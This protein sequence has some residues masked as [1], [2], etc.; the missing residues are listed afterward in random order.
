LERAG[1]DIFDGVDYIIPVPLHRSRL[2]KRRY[3]QAGLIAQ[4]LSKSIDK[5]CLVDGLKRTRAT[6]AQ[7]YLH[8]KERQKNV[9]NAFA[10]QNKYQSKLKG[11]TILLI[12][13]VYTTGATINECSKELLSHQVQNVR[14]LTL[15]RVIKLSHI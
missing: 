8:R 11:K 4:Y 13:D 15:S 14:V 12:D 5:P 6:P 7:G 1:A 10:V 3:N 2:W 9:K